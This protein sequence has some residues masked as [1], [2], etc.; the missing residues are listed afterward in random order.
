MSAADLLPIRSRQ[1]LFLKTII[2]KTIIRALH[3]REAPQSI[4]WEVLC[5]RG[6]RHLS[7]KNSTHPCSKTCSA[8]PKNPRA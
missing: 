8:R 4:P 3:V 7:K 6:R 1:L 5:A 2:R